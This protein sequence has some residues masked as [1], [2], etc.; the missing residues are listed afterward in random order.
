[1]DKDRFVRICKNKE[2]HPTDNL[3]TGNY[4]QQNNRQPLIGRS[5]GS[6]KLTKKKHRSVK[7]KHGKTTFLSDKAQ[8]DITIEELTELLAV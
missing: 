7:K 5:S 8:F 6:Y 4:R 1:M 3:K 2:D